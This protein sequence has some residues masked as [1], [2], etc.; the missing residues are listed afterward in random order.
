MCSW[1]KAASC[2]YNRVI[3]SVN[4][5]IPLQLDWLLLVVLFDHFSCWS[6][7]GHLWLWPV[8]HQMGSHCQGWC[9][10]LTILI[11]NT[12]STPKRLFSDVDVGLFIICVFLLCSFL[13]TSLV[14]LMGSTGCGGCSWPWVCETLYFI[15][16]V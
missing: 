3:F 16:N 15:N 12:I 10:L 9:Y 7:W 4:S 5:G 11:F 14:T 8:P 1:S 2:Y 13:H 6:V